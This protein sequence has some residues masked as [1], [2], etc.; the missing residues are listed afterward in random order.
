MKL[1]SI[2][3]F[4]KKQNEVSPDNIS[5]LG[6]E[7]SPITYC[8]LFSQTN[9]T[10]E[11]LNQLGIGRNDRVAIV[12]P[13]GPE[14]ATAFL[15]ISMGATAAPLNPS[16]RTPEF[17]FFLSDLDAKALIAQKGV[18]TDAIN[19]AQKLNIPV[20]ELIPDMNSVG[21]FDLYGE[22][23]A[24]QRNFSLAHP[25]DVALVL[26][27]S[28]T[29]SRPKIV[30]LTQRNLAASA[31][32]ILKT[33]KLT[34]A[35]RC[36]NIMPLFHIHGLMAATLASVAAGASLVCTPG[37]YSPR[38]FEWLDAFQPSWYTAVPTMHQGILERV[39][40]NQ[41]IL[42]KVQL[43]FIRSS[44]SSLAPQVMAELEDAF[45]CPVVEAYGMTEASHQMACNP[46]PPLIRK[47]G[48]V[49]P[50]AG[51]EVAIMQENGS[52]FINPNSIGEIVIRGENVTLGYANNPQANE[53]GFTNGWF[54]SGDQ[55]YQDDDGYFFITGRLKEIINRG[56]EKISPREIDEILLQHPGVTQALTFALPDKKLGE[57]IAAAVVIQEETLSER[58][59]RL[60]S[61][62]FLAPFKVPRRIII[63]DEIPKGP[64]GKF[65]RI[66]L[67]EKLGFKTSEDVTV[68]LEFEP[69]ETPVENALAEIWCEVL[70]LKEVS[71]NQMFLNLGGD[72]M[73]AAQI[74]SRIQLWME[75]ELS[76]L[77]FFDAPT[78]SEQAIIIEEKLLA[79]I[80]KQDKE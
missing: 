49:G 56:G 30:Q 74:V 63:L 23:Q 41:D 31:Q 18:E 9:R 32:N 65:Q 11:K 7:R 19:V 73:L 4:L 37:F 62:Q 17:E 71:V 35:D 21:I 42:A 79:I 50:A 80:D 48:S 10:L 8:S 36:L 39:P 75:I 25:D 55:G 46:L 13:N 43:R 40:D 51:P 64:T 52:E 29:T 6:L 60:Y 12:L 66:G 2:Y 27:T 45:K 26:H 20:I 69:P 34:H 58:D 72:S 22:K 67:A 59:L 57:D 1:T 5:I 38:F 77:D 3:E 53:T 24:V 14:M 44:S 61:A 28:G 68:E 16:Y 70:N 76:I 15:S 54:R 33:L 78:I 47:P